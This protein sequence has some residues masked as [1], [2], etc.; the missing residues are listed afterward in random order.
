MTTQGFTP[1]VERAYVGAVELFERANDVGVRQ[2][3]TVLR[4]LFSLYQLTAQVEPADKLGKDL[5]ALAEREGD[6][7][8]RID[9]RLAVGS[10]IVFADPPAGVAMLDE[11]ISFFPG[12]P[13][14]PYSMRG[15]ANDP[16]IS[17][18]TTAAFGSWFVGRPDKALE[19][20]NQALELAAALQHP[21][22]SAYAQFHVGLIHTLRREF[23]IAHERAAQAQ[24]I[25]VEHGLQIWNAVGGYLLG[26]TQTGI[27]R[28]DEGV[29]NIEA[30]LGLYRE[31]RSPPVFWPI[32]LLLSSAAYNRAGRPAGGLRHIEMTTPLVG[33]RTIG[34]LFPEFQIVRGDLLA[35]GIADGQENPETLYQSAYD[36]AGTLNARMSQLRAATRLARAWSDR[37]EGD[38]AV[39]A[40]A[41]LYSSF[42]E[43]LATA[44]LC[45]ARD[46]L[47]EIAPGDFPPRGS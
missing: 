28:G 22:T 32:L 39:Q 44:D 5:L 18:L 14:R 8:M 17:C 11:A 23:D 33:P 3:F 16:R 30:G 37:G 13:A 9:A 38:R 43:G 2:K 42:D 7:R 1:E 34:V 29:A 15:P 4:G 46:V 41:P 31:L 36:F 24:R 47:S 12:V 19:R 26:V 21:F 45:D 40:L 10:Q 6:A 20:A 25:G 27:G 35:T